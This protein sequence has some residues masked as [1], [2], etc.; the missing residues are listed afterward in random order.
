VVGVG[1]ERPFD[2]LHGFTIQGAPVLHGQCIRVVR[3]D[4]GFVGLKF[5]RFV[6]RCQCIVT[7]A[8]RG[9]GAPQDDPSLGVLRIGLHAFG[10]TLHQGGHLFGAHRMRRGFSTVSGRGCLA[11]GV[12]QLAHLIWRQPAAATTMNTPS[13]AQVCT[14]ARRF[15][16]DA[17][18]QAPV[19]HVVGV[20][21]VDMVEQLALNAVRRLLKPS[22]GGRCTQLRAASQRFGGRVAGN[23]RAVQF[24][25]ELV[26]GQRARRW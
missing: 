12:G 8:H 17:V 16:G 6:Q 25:I 21:L 20:G 3:Q 23:I 1:L 11:H 19:R 4:A 9:I 22:V 7:A 14:P 10:Q 13:K 2:E 26:I 24:R 18:G 15:G 5:H